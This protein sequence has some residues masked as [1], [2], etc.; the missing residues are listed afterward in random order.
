V[1]GRAGH[2]RPVQQQLADD[3]PDGP[4]VDGRAVVLRAEEELRRA[5]PGGR[6]SRGV[7]RGAGVEGQPGVQG[8]PVRREPERDDARREGA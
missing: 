1:K 3:A 4:E 2:E 8:Q 6:A 7:E 5:V